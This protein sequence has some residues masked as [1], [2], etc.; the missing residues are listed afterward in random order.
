M[1]QVSKQA[2]P[3]P[4]QTIRNRVAFLDKK[5]PVYAS[6]LGILG[7]LIVWELISRMELVPALYLPAPTAI[8]AMG[9]GMLTTGEIHQNLLASL[10]RIGAGYAIGASVGIIIGLLLGFF[11]WLD[12]VLTPVVFSIFPIPKIAL[13]PLF[14][15]WLGIG[16]TPKVTLIAIGVFFPAVINTYAGVKNVD[17]ILIKAAVTFGAKPFNVIRKVIL[18][19]SLPMIFAGLK[20]SASISLLL[21]VTSEMIAANSGV[22]SM[23]L[24]YG[25]LMMTMNLMV[26][27]ML[28]SVLGLS[29]NRLLEWLERKLLP[30]K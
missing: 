9:W 21:L 18:P 3:A 15:M 8:V 19:A 26:G 14:I 25:N 20:M 29:F 12:A 2:A 5:T 24:R 6:V 23:I 10:Y 27:V 17:P 13:L 30:W 11:R 22:G 16:E 28:L 7:I 1:E 4:R